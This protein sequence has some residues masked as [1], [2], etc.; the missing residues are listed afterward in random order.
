MSIMALITSPLFETFRYPFGDAI[1]DY[2][3]LG[4]FQINCQGYM[5]KYKAICAL[6]A[7]HNRIHFVIANIHDQ[8]SIK[9][10]NSIADS[11]ILNALWDAILFTKINKKSGMSQYL[12]KA[13]EVAELFLEEELTR[14]ISERFIANRSAKKIQNKWRVVVA[15]AYHPVCKRRLLREFEQ[16]SDF[17]L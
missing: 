5:V 11:K 16:M 4:N 6:A 14:K 17:V 2:I 13:V 1:G 10:P 3:V 15:D 7:P 9:I 8:H 12:Q